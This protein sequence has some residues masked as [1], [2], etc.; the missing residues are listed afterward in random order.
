MKQVR[1]IYIYI[2]I[3]TDRQTWIFLNLGE[4]DE[5]VYEIKRSKGINKI[6]KA[7][8]EWEKTFQ[9]CIYKIKT[10]CW[11]QHPVSARVLNRSG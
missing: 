5:K 4:S 7:P 1:G 9:K 6:D 3:H 11:C 8:D 2:A 10:K